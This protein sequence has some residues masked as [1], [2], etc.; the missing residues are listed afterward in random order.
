MLLTG[1]ITFPTWRCMNINGRNEIPKNEKMEKIIGNR[2]KIIFIA[3]DL[4]FSSIFIF[5]HVF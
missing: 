1:P 3:D 5:T 4:G 2:S